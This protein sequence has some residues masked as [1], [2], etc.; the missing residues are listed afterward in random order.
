MVGGRAIFYLVVSLN[1]P[2]NFG[3]IFFYGL[4]GTYLTYLFINVKFITM[5]NVYS[6]MGLLVYNAFEKGF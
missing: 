6:P 5:L 1:I 4:L 3:Y 2:H